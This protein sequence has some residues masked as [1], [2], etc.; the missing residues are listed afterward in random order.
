LPEAILEAT[1]STAYAAKFIAEQP[2]LPFEAIAPKLSA[3]MYDL[4]IVEK[5]I[6]DLTVN[7]TRFWVIVSE[8]LPIYFPRSQKQIK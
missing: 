1:P 3:E 8:N 6:Q 5:N 7:Q 4:N 2:E